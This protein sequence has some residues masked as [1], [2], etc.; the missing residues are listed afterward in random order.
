MSNIIKFLTFNSVMPR[1]FKYQ[2]NAQVTAADLER[3]PPL[4]KFK[5]LN[6]HIKITKNMPRTYNGFYVHENY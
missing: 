6:L 1:T 4:P 3:E 2:N 5:F